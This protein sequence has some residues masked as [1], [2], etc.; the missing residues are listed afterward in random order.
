VHPDID[1]RSE[2]RYIPS[3]PV[4]LDSNEGL[5]Q[6]LVPARRLS[7][8]GSSDYD[9]IV[10]GGTIFDGSGLPGYRA[11][12]AVKDGKIAKISGQIAARGAEELDAS[13]CNVSPGA[14]D[15]HCHYDAQ[16]NWDPYCT[17]SGWHG[18]TSLTIGQCGF[19]F[20]PTR[21]EDREANMEMMTRIEAIPMASMR[22]GMRW[23]WITFPQYLESLDRQGLGLNIG[24]L[25]PYSPLRAW[26]LGVKESRERTGVTPDE[27]E[28]IK[29][30]FR[31]GMTAG[32]FG[33]SADLSLEDRPGDGSYLPTQVASQDEYRA[34]ADVLAE[35]GVG[36]IGW[37]RGIPDRMGENKDCA[38]L[39]ELIQ[40]SG[41]PMQ[42][43]LV[44]AQEGTEGH[45]RAFEWLEDAHRRGLPMYAQSMSVNVSQSFTLA[46][47]NMFD[48]MPAW[49]EA[50]TGTRAE[51]QAKLA[52]PNR[53]PALKEA[54]GAGSDNPYASKHWEK[55]IIREV[56]NERNY[57]CEGLSV[58]EVACRNDKDPIDAF[59]D[60]A[61]DEDLD[62]LFA[63]A[64][65]HV[66]NADVLR[67]PYTHISLSDGGAHTRY[68][69]ATTWP[70]YFLSHWVRDQK[71][72]TLEQAHYKM[73][74]LPA[75]IAGFRDR[76]ILREGLA[77]DIIVY[78]L[79]KLGFVGGDPVYA[80]DFP[81]GERRLIQKAVGYR[82]TIVNGRVTMIENEPTG[83]LPGRLLRSYEMAI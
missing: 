11:D 41:R 65:V 43:G 31:A 76:G 68:H 50:T 9:L 58:A 66:P 61:V 46:D 14:V 32:A 8:M 18:I 64:D 45:I 34:L 63:V 51:R 59:L 33:F 69:V 70:T 17:L 60:L 48:T 83:T 78:D 30:I 62:T 73:S 52:D 27:L 81:G 44:I 36:H 39:E 23:D 72:M 35:F 24:S 77:A 12:L 49:L 55:V 1:E 4:S 19:G 42:W 25:F 28:Q 80:N 26:V 47:Y 20:A 57:R 10:R 15:L 3:L 13:G 79:D 54:M 6:S 82:Y 74:A 56:V 71:L 16:V 75:W 29:S 21:P 7:K 2:G 5:V 37:T 40:R 38:F 67:H 53:R 22:A